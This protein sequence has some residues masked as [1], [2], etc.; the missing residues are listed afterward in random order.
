MTACLHTLPLCRVQQG[1]LPATT[2]PGHP[3]MCSLPSR[4]TERER[5]TGWYRAFHP[6]AYGLK[7]KIEPGGNHKNQQTTKD[8]HTFAFFALSGNTL[9]T[10]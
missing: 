6:G 2:S 4:K 7:G 5:N 1:G 9:P 8:H 10:S 3:Q